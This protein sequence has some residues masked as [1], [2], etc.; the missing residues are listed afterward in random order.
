MRRKEECDMVGHKER[1]EIGPTLA[2]LSLFFVAE[3]S[4]IVNPALASIAACYPG[5]PFPTITLIST[6]PFFSGLAKFLAWPACVMECTQHVSASMV[7]RAT[8]LF[9]ACLTGG[10]F[11]SSFWCALIA[12]LTGNDDPRM[13]ILAGMGVMLV[14][15]AIWSAFTIRRR[16]PLGAPSGEGNI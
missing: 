1:K 7:A 15:G 8:S 12:L 13:P 14:L 2:L 4:F 11:L 5:V 3:A 10:S 6:L 9:F 16:A